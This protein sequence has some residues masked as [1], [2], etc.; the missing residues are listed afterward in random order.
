MKQ[1]IEKYDNNGISNKYYLNHLDQKN[2]LCIGYLYN[3]SIC[4]K[5]NYINGKLF[6]LDY[7]YANTNKPTIISYN[8]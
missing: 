3:G 6:G 5:S 8:L 4:W 7:W 2:G 1:I